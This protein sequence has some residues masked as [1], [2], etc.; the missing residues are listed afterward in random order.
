MVVIQEIVAALWQHDFAALA[1]PHVVGIV[2]LVMFAT[3]FLE[4]GLLPASFLPGDS[5][6]LLA[7]ALIAKGV[8]GFVPTLIILTTAASLGCWL[9]YI[10][11]RWL[12]NTKTVKGWLA[13]LPTKYHQR[14]TCMFDRHGLL[15]LLVG[16]FLAFVRTLLPT[17]AGISG[18]SNRRFQFFNWLSA[19]LWVG[20][21]TSL[22]Y[23]LSMIPF[24]KRH[25]D[26]V[27]TFLMILPLFLLVAG[28]FGAI[29]VVLKKK[30]SNA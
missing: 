20:V 21:V 8:M 23:A 22:G 4:N 30:Y 28:L 25:E 19:L 6:L 29:A 14:A 11:G 16:R 13:Q 1:N 24:V 9:S 15:A 27:M 18:L 7:G 26:Q 12:G 3:L 2:Y 17:M 10:Q 5:L